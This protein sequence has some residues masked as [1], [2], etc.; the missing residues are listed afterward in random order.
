MVLNND[1]SEDE[2][3]VSAPSE[4]LEELELDYL[5]EIKPGT[6][7]RIKCTSKWKSNVKKE[8]RVRKKCF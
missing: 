5:P 6:R 3:K 7:K 1:S 4:N 8:K 2:S